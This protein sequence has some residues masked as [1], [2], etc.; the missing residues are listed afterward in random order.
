[1][2]TCPSRC[3]MI[4]FFRKNDAF[5]F[6]GLKC[7]SVFPL[8]PHF[9]SES[10]HRGRKSA[11]KVPTPVKKAVFWFTPVN[12]CRK[13]SPRWNRKF[14]IFTGESPVGKKSSPG[15]PHC[16]FLRS[17]RQFEKS[18]NC[19]YHLKGWFNG[20]FDAIFGFLAS[21]NIPGWIFEAIACFNLELLK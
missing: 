21:K 17:L 20:N 6:Y 12:F 4:H 2:E 14:L 10:P 13:N 8:I 16:F 3:D 9:L 11:P 18:E 15:V 1:M 19:P 5:S 7:N